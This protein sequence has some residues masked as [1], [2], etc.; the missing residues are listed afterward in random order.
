[1]ISY[2]PAEEAAV[3][4]QDNFTSSLFTS[5]P[6][7]K[8]SLAYVNS[9]GSSPYL[10]VLSSAVITTALFLTVTEIGPDSPTLL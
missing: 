9:A 5:S 6:L 8:P 1:M 10:L 7:M 3:T 2:V 4:S